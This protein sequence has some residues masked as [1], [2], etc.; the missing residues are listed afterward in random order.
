M[1]AETISLI[2]SYATK[3]IGVL[4]A[5]WLSFKV[6]AWAEKTVTAALK[7]R[8]FDE[9]LSLFF[10]SLVRWLLIVMAVLG[11]LGVFGVETTSFAALIGA[12]GLAIGL[13]FQGTLSNFA[14]GIMILTFRPFA[15][16]DY[17]KVGSEEGIVKEIGLFITAIDTLDNRRIIIP[18]SGVI[19][20]NIENV[21]HNSHRR[22]D[23]DVGVSYATDIDA[24]RKAL[25]EAAAGVEGRD[26]ERGHQIF[27]KGLG[28]S[29]VDFQ[30]RVWCKTADYWTVWDRTVE[31][32]KKTLD[33]NEV[34]IPFP[35]MDLHVKDMPANAPVKSPLG[36]L[37]PRVGTTV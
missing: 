15:I 1:D 36:G 30:V 23:I 8:K 20:G 35:Q 6:A 26:S 2:T 16:G 27:L 13:S 3:I 17:I 9:A 28:E 32:V 34:E 5:I 21:T 37:R 12:A 33:S 4:I 10:G 19:A 31:A 25:D 18:N 14:A 29:S 22:V 11:C 7:A 24:A